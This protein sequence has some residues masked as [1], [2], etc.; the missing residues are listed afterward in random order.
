MLFDN[1]D[2][3]ARDHCA[4]ERSMCR[5]NIPSHLISNKKRTKSN[6]ATPT[7]TARSF[8][9][10]APP[11]DLHV[12]RRRRHP[13]FLPPQSRSLAAGEA[14]RA[15][16]RSGVLVS[17][18]CVS[19]GGIEQ[20][21]QDCLE[22]FEEAGAGAERDGDAA[23][24]LFLSLLSCLVADMLT[25]F[26]FFP[27][28]VHGCGDSYCC[29]LCAVS[30]DECSEQRITIVVGDLLWLACNFSCFVQCNGI[31]SF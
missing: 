22:V 18:H 1:N 10:M 2:S 15:A 19:R 30:I 24:E 16:V 4:A 6:Q 28:G 21:H 20:L 23:G 5:R 26:C 3:D 9:L 25:K 12:H 8:P 27:P 13:H 29:C 31:S 14:H 17:G 11:R 7:L